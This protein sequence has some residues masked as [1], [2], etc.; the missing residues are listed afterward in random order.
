MFFH[1]L[2]MALDGVRRHAEKGDACLG[3]IGRERREGN[4]FGGAG[5][6]VVFWIE[7][8]N[9]RFPSEIGQ[10]HVPAAVTRKVEIGRIVANLQ[11]NRSKFRHGKT[12]L[13][14]VF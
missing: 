14:P 11:F 6:R 2:V 13:L 1:E 9:Q 8:D 12:F 10:A 7:I 3:E 4:R 5:G